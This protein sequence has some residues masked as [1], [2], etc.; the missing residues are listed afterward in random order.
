MAI[1][2]C[3][4]CYDPIED[5]SMC[6]TCAGILVNQ[7]PDLVREI[8]F[9]PPKPIDYGL[10]DVTQ[11]SDLSRFDHASMWAALGW[12]VDMYAGS[13]VGVLFNLES[14]RGG[15][16]YTKFRDDGRSRK[17]ASAYNSA[18]K[19]ERKGICLNVFVPDI[20]PIVKQSIVEL[21]RFTDKTKIQQPLSS[22]Y[23]CSRNFISTEAWQEK[24][25]EIES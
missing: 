14:S 4:V 7:H 12:T 15:K 6:E 25:G 22:Y 18:Y 3:C 20:W 1:V 13:G 19:S 10:K 16:V 11:F 24:K 23:F 2:L 9:K 21:D 17:L 8:L 5:G